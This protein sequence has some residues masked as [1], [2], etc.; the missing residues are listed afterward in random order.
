MSDDEERII[1]QAGGLPFLE[2][3]DGPRVVMITS[4]TTGAWIF[5][6]GMIDPGETPEST[7]V[8]EAW[9]EAG[10]VGEVVGP[11]LG[12]YDSPRW[13]ATA[14]ISLYPLR[15]DELLDEWQEQSSRER[16]VVSLGEARLAMAPPLVALVDAF[17]RW[18][19]QPDE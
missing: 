18:Y 10:I 15:V 9:E 5:P 7:A 16:A 17:D 1:P 13:Q 19:S 11:V 3:A 12:S 14:R 2:G 4:R 6:K 8:T